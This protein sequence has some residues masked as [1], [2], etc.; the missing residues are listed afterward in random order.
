MS[1]TSFMNEMHRVS[2]AEV[3]RLAAVGDRV[4]FGSDFPSIPYPYA[5]AVEALVGLGLGEDWLRG[6][7]WG[8]AARVLGL[9]ALDDAVA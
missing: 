7:L 4:L 1:F 9:T 5:H 3:E 6:V 8:N 2:D